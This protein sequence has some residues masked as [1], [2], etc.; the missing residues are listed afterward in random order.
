MSVAQA[1]ALWRS[2]RQ[3]EACILCESAAAAGDVEA[4]NVLGEFYTALQR[5]EDAARVL[6][7]LASL[8]PDAAV[9]RRLGN[10]QQACRDYAGA[11]ANYRAS[12]QLEPA[13]VRAYNNLGQV[14]MLAHD[15]PGAQDSYERAIALDATYAI[16]HNNLGIVHHNRGAFATAIA[17]YE[18]A[19]KLNPTFAQAHY[20]CG[21]SLLRLR[22]AS[23][24]LEHFDRS[25]ALQPNL[26]ETRFVRGNALQALDRPEEALASYDAALALNPDHAECLS[27]AASVLL[28][29]KRPE[30]AK[31]RSERA[32]V[33][34]P[35]FPEALSNLGGALHALRHYEAALAAC[36]QALH[37]DPDFALGWSNLANVLQTYDRWDEVIEFS[38]RAIQLQPQLY[39]AYEQLATALLHQKRPADATSTY[40]RLAEIAPDKNGLPGSIRSTRNT[41]CDWSDHARERAALEQAVAAA[42]G[43]GGFVV[44]PF[45]FLSVSDSPALHLACARSFIADA[46]PSAWRTPVAEFPPRTAGRLRIAYLSAD[47]HQHATAMLMAGLFEQHDRERFEIIAV[48]FGPD[49]RDSMRL[50]LEQAFDQFI[51]ARS[52]DDVEVVRRL[53]ELRIDIAV[54]LKG[55][56]GDSRLGLFARRAAP[57]QVSYLGY[58]G[59]TALPQMDY[60]LADATVLPPEHESFYTEKVIWLPDCYQVNDDR[61]EIAAATPTRTELGLPESGFVFCC[62]NN[63]YKTTPDVFDIWM[64]LLQALPGSV[65]WLL[66]DNPD[67]AR[68]LKREAQ[69]RG[70]DPG[71]LIFA[72]RAGP[73]EHLAR[74]RQADLFLDTVPYNAHTTAA[75][76]LW[77]GLPVLTRLGNAFPG[78]VAASLVRA[79]GLPDLVTHSAE[80]YEARAVELARDPAL[81]LAF[82]QRLAINRSTYPLFDTRRFAR[83]LEAAYVQIWERRQQGLA[84]ASFSVPPDASQQQGNS[85]DS[86]TES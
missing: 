55:H 59:S 4:L 80:E 71:R 41:A 52:L 12:L 5:P 20:N 86:V 42:A 17:C 84:P 24:A 58:P 19:L 62:F 78:R 75:D 13:N 70:I 23:E 33:L 64:R 7:R 32:L 68:N 21:N 73:A 18:R 2:G 3:Q 67:A 10:A 45:T 30:E 57:L 46:I 37:I 9:L 29:L 31:L 81:L 25:L 66:Q 47:F 77:A 83:H 85:A 15:L 79:V 28:Q 61:R 1:I 53:R 14:L 34:R 27:N 26:A 16:A 38:E 48:S 35:G 36:E 54:D 76:A 50:R 11:A 72:P 49:A 60:V 40:L 69:S 22:R 65:L 43:A 63:N 6:G 51:N 44:Q 39:E 74:H 8:R 56:T 82:R